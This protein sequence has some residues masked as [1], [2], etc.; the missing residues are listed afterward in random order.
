MCQPTTAA[1]DSYSD[2]AGQ[3]PRDLTYRQV[4]HWI[5]RYPNAFTVGC[6]RARHRRHFAGTDVEALTVMARLVDA[7]LTVAAAAAFAARR[8]RTGPLSPYVT[9]HVRHNPAS[10]EPAP[11]A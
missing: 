9:I 4:D 8:T 1:G 3:L 7:G 6:A 11:T 5:T 10:G 2:I